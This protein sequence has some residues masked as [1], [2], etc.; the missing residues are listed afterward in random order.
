MDALPS[1][2]LVH[3]PMDDDEV[4]ASTKQCTSQ[5]VSVPE[6]FLAWLSHLGGEKDAGAARRGELTELNL[7]W[8]QISDHGAKITAEFLKRNVTV[9]DIWLTFCAIGPH[10]A[11]VIAQAFRHNKTVDYFNIEGNHVGDY[12][13]EAIIDVLR[14]NV[15]LTYVNLYDTNISQELQATIE[16]LTEIRNKTL[17]PNAVRSASLC[18][19]AAG[20]TIDDTGVLTIVPKEIVKMIAMEV[21][22]TRKDPIW[23]NALTESERTGEPGD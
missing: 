18:I 8:H 12:G 13:A 4:V 23:I 22:A 2:L 11:K 7:S 5:D 6:N 10:H 14:H 16:Y 1:L 17:I 21:W 9:I 19:I 3:R 20:R 15:C